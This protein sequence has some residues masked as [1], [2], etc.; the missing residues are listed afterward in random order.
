MPSARLV[1]YDLGMTS[2]GLKGVASIGKKLRMEL[3]TLDFGVL[4]PWMDVYNENNGAYAW[5]PAVIFKEIER[6]TASNSKPQIIIWLDA[7]NVI[8]H[9][10]KILI[11][12][13]LVYEFFTT[14]S[15][16]LIHEWTVIS[17]R[18]TLDP[19][20][21]HEFKRNLNAA[22]L[23]F[24]LDSAR[25]Q[26]LLLAWHVCS[27]QK[28]LIAPSESN[29]DNHRFDQSLITL[30]AYERDL[31]PFWVPLGIKPNSFGLLCH[32]DEEGN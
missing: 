13:T 25:A 26:N 28:S 1:V 19:E 8:I 6:Q 31:V 3:L 2:D 29:L 24:K 23:G 11:L 10:P 15:R 18:R 30:L 20:Q 17:T 7:G 21:K 5:K 14:A 32:Q 16:G 22:I 12:L 4:S 27:Q 9:E